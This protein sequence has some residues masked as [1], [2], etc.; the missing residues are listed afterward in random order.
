MF[1]R[2]ARAARQLPAAVRAWRLRGIGS[3]RGTLQA[4]E[5]GPAVRLHAGTRGEGRRVAQDTQ[6]PNTSGSGAELPGERQE[7]GH[8]RCGP[9]PGQGLRECGHHARCL[10][11]R[12]TGAQRE[13]THQPLRVAEDPEDQLQ[14]AQLLRETPTRRVRAVR[15]DGRLQAGQPPRRQKAV[16]DLRRTP[17]LLQA[18]VAGAG[19]ARRAV[20]AAGLAVPVQRPHALRVTRRAAAARAATLRAHALAQE[21]LLAQHG[22]SGSRRQG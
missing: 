7:T 11:L 22:R 17:H 2:H 21:D 14:A 18:D 10:L 8:V 15:V 20:P 13:I 6:R 19:G 12:F 1:D 4:V 5:T 16:E 3:G 9:P